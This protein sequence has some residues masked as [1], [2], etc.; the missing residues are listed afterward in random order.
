MDRLGGTSE[1]SERPTPIDLQGDS[2][3]S[4][5]NAVS[6][7]GGDVFFLS[8]ACWLVIFFLILDSTRIHFFTV[9][10][11]AKGGKRA[12]EKKTKAQSALRSTR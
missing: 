10:T 6:E 2:S 5:E 4:R 9:T 7:A 8:R 3:T 12:R 11:Q 1:T